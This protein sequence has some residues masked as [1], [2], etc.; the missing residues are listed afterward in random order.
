MKRD[1]LGGP[2]T[3]KVQFIARVQRN[4]HTVFVRMYF[5]NGYFDNR[6]SRGDAV[7]LQLIARLDNVASNKIYDLDVFGELGELKSRSVRIKVK[8]D[9]VPYCCTT[10]R[11]VHFPM[12]EKVSHE[13]DRMEH[14]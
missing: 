11:I 13:L 3:C 6:I 7:K 9:D 10:A 4:Q 1:T 5:V 12:L 14:I 2:L 8:Q